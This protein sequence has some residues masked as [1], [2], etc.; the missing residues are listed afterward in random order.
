MLALFG[1]KLHDFQVHLYLHEKH[2]SH[3]WWR[4]CQ[5]IVLESEHGR[6][7]KVFCKVCKIIISFGQKLTDY[8]SNCQTTSTSKDMIASQTVHVVISDEC[9]TSHF[10]NF[11]WNNAIHWELNQWN[12]PVNFPMP[13]HKICIAAVPLVSGLAIELC[14]QHANLLLACCTALWPLL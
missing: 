9:C 10:L 1:H 14:D 13:I 6:Q 4:F 8:D 3:F 5:L 2:V 11:H 7:A 12:L